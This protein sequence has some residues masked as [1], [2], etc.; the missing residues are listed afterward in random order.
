MKQNFGRLMQTLAQRYGSKE[1]VV[2]VERNRRYT[3]DEFHRLT[4][5]IANALRTTLQVGKGDTFMLILENDNL[6]LL[7]FPAIYMSKNE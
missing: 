2:N 5:R 6:A 1:A 7:Q 3:F 4:N